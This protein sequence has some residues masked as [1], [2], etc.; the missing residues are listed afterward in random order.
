MLAV[1][2]SVPPA[3]EIGPAAGSVRSVGPRA[4]VLPRESVPA[5]SVVPPA[6]VLLPER[7]SVPVPS[8]SS[9]PPELVRL[10]PRITLWPFVSSL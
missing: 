9:D 8:F 4:P 7:E 2:W 10:V 6:K 5:V 1:Y 3:N